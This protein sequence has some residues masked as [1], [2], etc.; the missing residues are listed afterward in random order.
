LIEDF[1][2]Q[3]RWAVLE[4]ARLLIELGRF[5]EASEV[6]RPEL[7][8]RPQ[9]AEAQALGAVAELGAGRLDRAEQ[10][11]R[12]AVSA[13]RGDDVS[14]RT[15]SEVLQA[16]GRD[17]EAEQAAR[18]ATEADARSW[19]AWTR[20]AVVLTGRPQSG[21]EAQEAAEVA[22]RLAPA[23]PFAHQTLARAAAAADDLRTAEEALRRSLELDPD[24]AA[25]AAE[26]AQV[27]ASRAEP[28]EPGGGWVKG[29]LGRR[30]QPGKQD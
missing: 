8:R 19:Q 13:S 12:E 5:E 7:I 3:H 14:W 29:L 2:A 21:R 22:V 23:A 9:D 10:L 1:D 16:Q 11:A 20:L 6:L 26:L 30:R 4:R 18:S 28:Q 27:R 25:V 24:D 15:L 17:E